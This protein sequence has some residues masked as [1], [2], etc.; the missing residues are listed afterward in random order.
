MP[1]SLLYLSQGTDEVLRMNCI[2]SRAT[3]TRLYDNHLLVNT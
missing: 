2:G 1:N 3:V